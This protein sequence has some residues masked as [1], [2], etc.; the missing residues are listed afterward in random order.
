[1]PDY[2]YIK[3]KCTSSGFSD[4]VETAKYFGWE[5]IDGKDIYSERQVVDRIN[6]ATLYGNNLGFSTSS[7]VSHKEKTEFV[8]L[9]FKRDK[10]I[11][12]YEK[13]R[14]LWTFYQKELGRNIKKKSAYSAA[15][16]GLVWVL[17]ISLIILGF[18][19]IEVIKT[20]G[21]ALIIIGA[22]L[23][24]GAI[25]LDIFFNK[26][27]EAMKKEYNQKLRKNLLE[28]DELKKAAKEL[29]KK[30]NLKEYLN[31]AVKDKEPQAKTDSL[32]DAPEKL[33]KLKELFDSNLITKEEYEE[34]RKKIIE[35]F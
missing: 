34:K 16:F 26:Q 1:M 24:V 7:V 30:V 22:V 23:T 4:T 13:F 29:Y 5:Y 35:S 14:D 27:N 25:L 8:I 20:A 10:E 32:C 28:I 11:P 6:G 18:F 33:K 17:P 21:I 15:A 2:E 31:N 9:N 3:Y 19:L 12:S